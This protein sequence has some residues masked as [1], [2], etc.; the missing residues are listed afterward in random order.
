MSPEPLLL[1]L[2]TSAAVGSVALYRGH[3]L[4]ATEVMPRRGE[5]AARLVPAIEQVLREGD[6]DRGEIEGIVVGL[7]P[8]SFTGVR[9]AAATARGLAV[10][11]EVPVWGWSSLAAAAA[12]HRIEV[13]PALARRFGASWELDLPDEADGWPRYVLLDARGQRVYRACYRFLPGRLETLTS[14]RGGTVEE[15]LEEELPSNVLF[16][17]DGAVRHAITL[18]EHGCRVLPPPAGLP[19]AQGLMRVHRLHPWAPPYSREDR[20]E[21]EYIRSSSARPLVS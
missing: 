12:S 6:V 10:G 17:G 9:I 13:P 14:P 20:W 5:H 18:E 21:P 16:C 11:L 7:G 8:G 15:V 3:R 2:E 19:T 4:L 1:A